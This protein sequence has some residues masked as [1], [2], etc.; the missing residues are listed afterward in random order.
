MVPATNT[1]AIAIGEL[2]LAGMTHPPRTSIPL[3]GQQ[4]AIKAC[5]VVNQN[6]LLP[7]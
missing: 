5:L 4:I 1:I 3:P 6:L 2:A 7:F